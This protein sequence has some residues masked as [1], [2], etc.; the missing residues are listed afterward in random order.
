MKKLKSPTVVLRKWTKYQKEQHK[1]PPKK[2]AKARVMSRIAK[3]FAKLCG[4]KS[5]GEVRC[6]AD[7]IKK[8]IAYAYEETT[9]SYQYKPQKYTPDFDLF[10]AEGKKIHIEYKGKLDN[11]TRKKMLAVKECNPDVEICFVFEKPNNKIRKGSKTTYGMWADK[12]GFKWSDQYV[13]EEW[14]E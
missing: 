3:E 10:G 7:L 12:A 13:N 14:L 11:A 9:L 1:L 5:M 2:R 4:M 8:R 6:A